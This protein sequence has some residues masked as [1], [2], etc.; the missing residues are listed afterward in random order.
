MV[1]GVRPLRTPSTYAS[2]P[3]GVEVMRSLAAPVGW[4]VGSGGVGVVV[5]GGGVVVGASGFAFVLSD[6][7]TE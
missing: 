1:N 5:V 4:G 7:D 2:A 6:A 3:D